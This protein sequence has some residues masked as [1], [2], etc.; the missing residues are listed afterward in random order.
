MWLSI[1]FSAIEICKTTCLL[2]KMPGQTNSRRITAFFG[3]RFV[4]M[5]CPEAWHVTQQH[6]SEL[7]ETQTTQKGNGTVSSC[8]HLNSTRPLVFG[9]PVLNG[10]ILNSMLVLKLTHFSVTPKHCSWDSF[11]VADMVLK[12]AATDLVYI[13][14]QSTGLLMWCQ[15]IIF[16]HCKWKFCGL[17]SGKCTRYG[18]IHIKEIS[19]WTPH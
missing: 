2:A 9:L 10:Q 15:Q 16:W 1:L 7:C 5:P 13:Y 14:L 6:T 12:P 17:M 19:H 11:C 3:R 8:K 18:T 4:Q